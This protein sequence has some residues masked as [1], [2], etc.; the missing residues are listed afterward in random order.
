MAV[1]A[2]PLGPESRDGYTRSAF[3]HWNAGADP[4]DGCHTPVI[5]TLGLTAEHRVLSTLDL[6]LVGN[7]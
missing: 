4:S 2:L 3:R 6:S 1:S 5:C 7:C